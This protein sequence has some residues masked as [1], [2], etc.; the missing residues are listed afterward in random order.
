MEWNDDER[1]TSDYL[2]RDQQENEFNAKDVYESLY[3]EK[4]YTHLKSSYDD[5]EY[6]DIEHYRERHIKKK[7]VE[8][9]TK[10]FE[11][12]DSEYEE[13]SEEVSN[14]SDSDEYLSDRYELPQSNKNR[15]MYS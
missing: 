7:T 14:D 13:S 5:C 2:R 12:E 6:E 9:Y 8:Y 1:N 3:R 4:T 15:F 11:T 10:Y